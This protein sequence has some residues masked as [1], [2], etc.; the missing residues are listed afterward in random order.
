[1]QSGILD[2]DDYKSK[3]SINLKILKILMLFRIKCDLTFYI[4]LNSTSI[5]L[6]CKLVV[7]FA[8]SK[9]ICMEKNYIIIHLYNLLLERFELLYLYISYIIYTFI[10]LRGAPLGKCVRNHA[11]YNAGLLKKF[12]SFL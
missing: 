3:M 8:N 11:S 5:S 1:M 10:G 7:V 2:T 9:I 6:V 4:K 12:E